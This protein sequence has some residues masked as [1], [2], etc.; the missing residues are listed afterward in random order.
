MTKPKKATKRRRGQSASKAVLYREL[1]RVFIVELYADVRGEKGW[2]TGWGP[3]VGIALDWPSAKARKKE[4]S[5][6]NPQDKFRIKRY[7]AV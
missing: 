2:Y 7:E 4:W 1:P 5:N 6:R 3:T